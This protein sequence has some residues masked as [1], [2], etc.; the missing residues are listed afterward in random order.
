M[1]TLGTAL[2]F[3]M[4]CSQ[5]SVAHAQPGLSARQ[6]YERGIAHYKIGEFEQAIGDFKAAYAIE[7][8][9]VLLFNLAQSYRQLGDGKRALFF[10]REF[11][12]HAPPSPAR[13]D[14]EHMVAELEAPPPQAPSPPS[15]PAPVY[16]AAQAPPPPRVAETTRAAPVLVSQKHGLGRHGALTLVA[17]T[18]AIG[19]TLV[20]VGVVLS[21]HAARVSDS[22]ESIPMTPVWNATYRSRYDDGRESAS[23]ATAMYVIGGSAITASIISAVICRR[24]LAQQTRYAAGDLAW[25]F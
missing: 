2:A 12:A 18:A 25:H 5:V 7:P 10:Y 23:A 15:G 3:V 8:S 21:V 14:A 11:V 19:T 20:L 24:V 4:C 16:R 13:T 22:L 9:D 17:S 1:K 6:L